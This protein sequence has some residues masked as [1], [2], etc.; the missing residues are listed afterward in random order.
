MNECCVDQDDKP[1]PTKRISNTR[2]KCMGCYNN[3]DWKEDK[4][5]GDEE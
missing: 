5:K 4:T 1:Y 3:F 2:G